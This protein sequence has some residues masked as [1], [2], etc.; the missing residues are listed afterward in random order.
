[1]KVLQ[2]KKEISKKFQQAGF[3]QPVFEAEKLL[4][5]TLDLNSAQ[6]ITAYEKNLNYFQVLKTSYWLKKRLKGVP[7]AYL[8]KQQG[9]YNLEFLVNKNVLIPRPESELFIDYLKNQD[10]KNK[11]II[12]IGTGSGCLIISLIKNLKAENLDSDTLLLAT[13]I[14]AKALKVAKKNAKKYNLDKKIIFKPANLLKAVIES[15]LDIAKK[16]SITIMANLPYV[17]E[18]IWQSSA[19][20]KKEP[21]QALIAKDKGL[22]YY[23]KLI[24]EVK[25]LKAKS[26][27]VLME[28]NPQQ[29]PE[30]SDYIKKILPKAEITIIKDLS[31]KDRLVVVSNYN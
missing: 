6:L 30:L 7:L 12:D 26:I 28:I 29:K 21:K 15:N 10:F 1:M 14:S 5:S 4:E 3:S 25:D 31:Q 18:S 11:A 23:K 13:D 2:L 20:I 27:E 8:N 24:K 17:E 19:S 9:F 22:Y 16:E